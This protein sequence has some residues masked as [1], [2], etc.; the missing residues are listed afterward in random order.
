VISFISNFGLVSVDVRRLYNS[1]YIKR[2]NDKR[3]LK[4]PSNVIQGH[5]TW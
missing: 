4:L 2:V 3:R 1:R 5:R